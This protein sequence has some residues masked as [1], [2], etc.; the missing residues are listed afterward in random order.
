[1]NNKSQIENGQ[2]EQMLNSVT[3]ADI[4]SVQPDLHKTL[5]CAFALITL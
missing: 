1:M 2:P 3:D 4:T 5:C